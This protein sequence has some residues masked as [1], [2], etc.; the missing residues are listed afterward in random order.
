MGHTVQQET[1]T[2]RESSEMRNVSNET[3]KRIKKITYLDMQCQFSYD[4]KNY[5]SNKL[6]RANTL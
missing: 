3:M 6:K 2:Q 4:P 1:T 5:L